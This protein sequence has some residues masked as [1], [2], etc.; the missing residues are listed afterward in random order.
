MSK[1][2]LP[3]PIVHE[4]LFFVTRD[5]REFEE[6]DEL[7]DYF[8]K[9]YAHTLSLLPMLGKPTRNDQPRYETED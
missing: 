8:Q 3:D 1:E 4:L 2:K 5:T 7:L 6:K 9:H